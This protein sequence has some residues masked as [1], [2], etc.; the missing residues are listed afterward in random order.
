MPPHHTLAP[1]SICTR[2]RGSRGGTGECWAPSPCQ[3][4]GLLRGLGKA[5]EPVGARGAQGR[6]QQGRCT[7][8]AMQQ[9]AVALG[10]GVSTGAKHTPA[11]R[12]AVTSEKGHST[13]VSRLGVMVPTLPPP[14]HTDLCFEHWLVGC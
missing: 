11:P 8:G 7:P 13:S 4:P 5:A 3:A 2:P 6:A 10:Q 12:S 14:P 1:G 9:E